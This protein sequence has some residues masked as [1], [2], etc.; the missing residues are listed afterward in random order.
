M[1][2]RTNINFLR[3][4]IISIIL[5]VLYIGLWIKISG[6]DFL[7]Y[8]EQ[9]MTLMGYFPEFARDPFWLTVVFLGM[10]VLSATLSFRAWL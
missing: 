3:A 7:T 10:S 6:D 2:D 1:K 5:P 9:V 4:S 8:N